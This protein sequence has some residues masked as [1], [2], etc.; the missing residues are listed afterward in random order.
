MPDQ[1]LSHVV[2]A[3]CVTM[4]DA[5]LLQLV[6]NRLQP[7]LQLSLPKLLWLCQLCGRHFGGPRLMCGAACTSNLT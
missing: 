3:G 1:H 2:G 5:F 4:D 6:T 7:F